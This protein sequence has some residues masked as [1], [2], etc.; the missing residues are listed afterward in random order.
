VA[1][2]KTIAQNASD[3]SAMQ[4]YRTEAAKSSS[5]AQTQNAILDQMRGEA[6]GFDHGSFANTIQSIKKDVGSLTQAFGSAMPDSVAS[7][8]NFQKNS[9]TLARSA[10][11]SLSPRVGVQELELVQKYLPSA[12]MSSQGFNRIA[13]QLQGLNDYQVARTQAAANFQ[14]NPGQFE[15]QFAR[16]VTPAAFIVN[17][18]PAADLQTFVSGLNQSAE[19]RA[20]LATIRSGIAFA[21]QNGL[22]QAPG[23]GAGAASNA[24][25]AGGQ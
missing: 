14:G 13:D 12:T 2:D 10:A 15:A 24:P 1:T 7:W 4:E 8:E 18:M 6:T 19:G 9:G 25:S 20:T 17:R 11:S 3:I 22:M 5:S 16:S 23:G 21:R